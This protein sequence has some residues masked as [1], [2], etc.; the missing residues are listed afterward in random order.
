MRTLAMISLLACIISGC[1]TVS[2]IQLSSESI[3]LSPTTSESTISIVLTGSGELGWVAT[4]NASWLS[5]SPNSGSGAISQLAVSVSSEAPPTSDASAVVTIAYTGGV[6]S[7]N[8]FYTA[9]STEN[10]NGPGG[11]NTTFTALEN[12]GDG[13]PIVTDAFQDLQGNFVV[14]GYRFGKDYSFIRPFLVKFDSRGAL[15][16]TQHFNSVLA[17]SSRGLLTAGA[18]D[19]SGNYLVTG[20]ELSQTQGRA[21]LYR[22]NQSTLDVEISQFVAQGIGSDL[23]IGRDGSYYVGGF[24]LASNNITYFL[25]KFNLT[26]GSGV[27]FLSQ[28]FSREFSRSRNGNVDTNNAPFNLSLVQLSNGNIVIAGSQAQDERSVGILLSLVTESGNAQ[29]TVTIDSSLGQNRYNGDIVEV[30]SG[31]IAIAG[32]QT[33]GNKGD[34]SIDNS[35]GQFY[36]AT[37]NSSTLD[38]VQ[39]HSFDSDITPSIG[40]LDGLGID[41]NLIAHSDGTLVVAGNKFRQVGSTPASELDIQLIGLNADNLL[42]GSIFERT[43]LRSGLEFQSGL[44]ATPDG[45]MLIAGFSA[46]LP[47]PGEGFTG[48]DVY[49]IRT[50]RSGNTNKRGTIQAALDVIL[51]SVESG[52]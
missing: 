43:L 40:Y 39:L 16:N 45:G 38:V 20:T 31:L 50:D 6:K 46:P 42:G 41:V 37:L 7:L 34:S 25:R 11:S 8:V 48:G 29:K 5:L 33:D 44:V 1:P 52:N 2:T 4:T 17:S 28:V 27:D 12:I 35:P 14:V 32:V 24:E 10:P 18:V 22:I 26:Q 36:T 23:I 9:T 13:I 47:A 21:V 30:R 15:L 51:N 49:L 19:Q 3:T